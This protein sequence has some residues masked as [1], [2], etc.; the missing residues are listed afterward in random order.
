MSDFAQILALCR[1]R[2]ITI[3]TIH[4]ASLVCKLPMCMVGIVIIRARHS[5]KIQAKNWYFTAYAR[6]I[7]TRQA[8]RVCL[9]R[10]TGH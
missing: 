8:L 4:M 10:Y 1:A 3:P 5:A 2:I 7:R 6:V 9:S